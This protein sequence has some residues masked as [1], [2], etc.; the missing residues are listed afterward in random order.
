MNKHATE[1]TDKNVLIDGDFDAK[2]I[3]IPD[4]G[5]KDTEYLLVHQLGRE[6]ICCRLLMSNK[7]C[8]LYV[9]GKD[10]NKVILKFTEDNC[11]V[12]IE[13]Y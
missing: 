10:Q 7:S 13:V 1:L 9:S 3:R 11:D 5:A 6:P 8:I 12:N 2:V 4:T